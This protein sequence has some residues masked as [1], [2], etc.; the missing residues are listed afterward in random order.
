VVSTIVT[1]L[2]TTTAVVALVVPMSVVV[3]AVTVAGA[4]AVVLARW[5]RRRQRRRQ[6]S[7]QCF[8]G[9]ERRWS[10]SWTEGVQ[11]DFLHHGI[12]L[13]V[14]VGDDGVGVRRRGDRGP[15]VQERCRSGD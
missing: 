11:V 15:P 1:V 3:A 5:A 10:S 13:D 12:C 2:A 7:G 6:W 14:E 8:V 9:V 4:A